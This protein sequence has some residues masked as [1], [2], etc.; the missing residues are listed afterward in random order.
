MREK[1]QPLQIRSGKMS[2]IF[3]LIIKAVAD[4]DFYQLTD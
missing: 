1:Q 2:G 3:D 4:D